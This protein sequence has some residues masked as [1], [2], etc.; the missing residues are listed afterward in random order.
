LGIV[1]NNFTYI[2]PPPKSICDAIPVR[3]LQLRC[4]LPIDDPIGTIASLSCLSLALIAVASS[5]R[6]F[7]PEKVNFW[8]EASTGA[9]STIAYFLAK[10][11]SFLPMIL[12]SP[13]IFLGLF[14]SLVAMRST[15]FTFYLI[16]ASVYFTAVG[17]GYFV[18]IIVPNSIN[19]LAAVVFMLSF[20]MFS[21]A[22]PTLNELNKMWFPLPYMGNFS[23]LR[24][25]QE[26]LYITEVEQYKSV[27][28]IEA[29]LKILGYDLDN[30]LLDI[31]MIILHG[32]IFRVL[33]LLALIFWNRDKKK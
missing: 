31:S 1:F 14:L 17:V 15:Y 28:N 26:A 7:A 16:F 30:F 27:Y 32:I 13:A 33:S 20:M 22:R 19:Q 4:L 12:F 10:D 24:F 3:D 25:A 29:G 18:S 21:G 5:L 6:V 11:L 2:G 9:H 23:F 8:R